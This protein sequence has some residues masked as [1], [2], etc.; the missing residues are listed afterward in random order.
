MH[1]VTSHL[2]SF[3]SMSSRPCRRFVQLLWLSLLLWQLCLHAC[4]SAQ[5]SIIKREKEDNR[6][7]LE[8]G[9]RDSYDDVPEQDLKLI[10]EM[11]NAAS[12]G[13]WF[14]AQR[15]FQASSKSNAAVFNTAMA[16]ALRCEQCKKGIDIFQEMKRDRV[17][18]NLKSYTVAKFGFLPSVGRR[19][20]SSASGTMSKVKILE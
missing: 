15:A 18:K 13:E 2:V 3:G 10:Q 9:A 8:I 12:R 20:K 1:T 7:A 17:K 14:A 16:A 11:R 5:S 19:A 6:V 4:F